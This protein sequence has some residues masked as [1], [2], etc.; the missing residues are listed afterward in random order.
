[1]LSDGPQMYVVSNTSKIFGAISIIFDS[2]REKLRNAFPNGYMVLP[3]SIHEVIIT[4]IKDKSM[5]DNMVN[6]VNEA[7]VIEEEQLSNRAYMF[8]DK[9]VA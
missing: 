6:E 5:L 3:S 1:M 9:E 2:T 4:E 8:I 7:Q